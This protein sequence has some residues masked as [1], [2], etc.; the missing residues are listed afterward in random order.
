MQHPEVRV[1]R[2]ASQTC[3]L[4]RQVEAVRRRHREHPGNQ[5]KRGSRCF[6][7]TEHEYADQPNAKHEL[8]DLPL[9]KEKRIQ[10]RCLAPQENTRSRAAAKRL[11]LLHDCRIGTF[12][13]PVHFLKILNHAKVQ[14][15]AGKEPTSYKKRCESPPM[16]SLFLPTIKCCM[17]ILIDRRAFLQVSAAG[18]LAKSEPLQWA[19]LSDTHIPEDPAF[20]QRGFLPVRNLQTVVDQ[21]NASKWHGQIV[22]GDLTL[23]NGQPADYLR[24]LG[25]TRPLTDRAPLA[26]SLGNHDSRPNAI[27]ALGAKNT[28]PN[29]WV[30]AF[31]AGPFQIVVL[32]SLY[33]T[34][35]APGFLG[36]VQR[37]WL[38][39]FLEDH[40]TKPVLVFVHHT[41][42][43]SDSS[44]LDADRFLNIVTPRRQVKAVFYGHSHQYK[45]EIRDG[46]HLVNQPAVGYNFADDQPVGWLAAELTAQNARLTLHAI[47]GNRAQDG[48]SQL[49]NWR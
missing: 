39:K 4:R 13:K 5:Q 20:A 22:N 17:P 26:L 7:I 43:D 37:E 6:S 14:K 49:L 10:F 11:H 31:E 34:N 1:Q 24:F 16:H 38:A 48:Q 41:L 47:G 42:D 32:D 29:K 19:L 36:K 12:Q 23:R 25:I 8:R 33:E 27:A 30:S 44:L 21:V 18:L 9:L 46:L 3:N 2:Q 45:Y 15:G 35:T 28:V 40:T